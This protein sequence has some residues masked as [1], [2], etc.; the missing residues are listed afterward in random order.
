M[1][2]WEVIEATADEIENRGWCMGELVDGSGY[3]C[4]DGALAIALGID[5]DIAYTDKRANAI[6]K[7]IIDALDIK[8]NPD[9]REEPAEI[10]WQWNDRN[11]WGTHS[12]DNNHIWDPIPEK[13]EAEKQRILDGLREAAKIVRREDEECRKGSSL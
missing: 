11:F 12:L 5:L 10:L 3:V 8:G 13:M 1:E 9:L 4:V 7:R 2:D 6:A